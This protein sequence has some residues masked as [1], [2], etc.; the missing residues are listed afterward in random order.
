MRCMSIIYML[1]ACMREIE[2][3]IL[4]NISMKMFARNKREIPSSLES[5]T[6]SLVLNACTVCE[7][8]SLKFDPRGV[9][10]AFERYRFQFLNSDKILTLKYDP[11]S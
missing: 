9:N 4:S 8:D 3:A 11:S 7:R 5:V 6:E 1:T 2:A 10:R